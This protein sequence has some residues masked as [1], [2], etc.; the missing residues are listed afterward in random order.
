MLVKKPMEQELQAVLTYLTEPHQTS[1]LYIP[2]Q[3][4]Y[5]ENI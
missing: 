5:A 1:S 2:I 3:H 4:A